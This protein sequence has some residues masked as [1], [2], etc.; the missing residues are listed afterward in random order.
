MRDQAAIC[1]RVLNYRPT[2]KRV[3]CTTNSEAGGEGYYCPCAE[4]LSVAG[5]CVIIRRFS[6]MPNSETG[7]GAEG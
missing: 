7:K 2:V 1:G 5:F 6:G 4:V 3:M